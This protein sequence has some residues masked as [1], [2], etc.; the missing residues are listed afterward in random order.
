[1]NKHAYSKAI[2]LIGKIVELYGIDFRASHVFT[3]EERAVIDQ[4]V[5]EWGFYKPLK[6]TIPSLEPGAER[7][8]ERKASRV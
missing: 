8:P 7:K 2:F 6:E 1:M 4:A 5:R 3:G